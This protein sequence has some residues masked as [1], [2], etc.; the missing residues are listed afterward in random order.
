MRQVLRCINGGAYR[1]L[2]HEVD[3]SAE[4]TE[5]GALASVHRD[6]KRNR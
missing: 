1:T 2:G 6:T 3:I 5:V 4:T